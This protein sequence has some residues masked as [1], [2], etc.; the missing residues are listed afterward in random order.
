MIYFKDFHLIYFQALK[1]YQLFH[2]ILLYFIFLEKCKQLVS[3][4]MQ[5]IQMDLVLIKESMY[6]I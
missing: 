6:R 3:K 1:L 2:L 5:I 4:L